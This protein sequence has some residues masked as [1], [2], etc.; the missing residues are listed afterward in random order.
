MYSGKKVKCKLAVLSQGGTV[1][2]EYLEI[3][4]GS[5]SRDSSELQYTKQPHAMN[6]PI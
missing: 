3:C 2:W 6:C 4:K 5:A 1:L